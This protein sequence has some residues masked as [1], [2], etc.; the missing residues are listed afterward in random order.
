MKKPDVGHL[1]SQDEK[2]TRD[3]APDDY[4]YDDGGTDVAI[5]ACLINACTLCPSKHV[6]SFGEGTKLPPGV[7]IGAATAVMAAGV[8]SEHHDLQC[9]HKCL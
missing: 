8:R 6:Y 9:S 4:D 5:P 2:S 3:V 1:G 7:G